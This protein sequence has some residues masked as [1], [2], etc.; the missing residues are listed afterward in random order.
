MSAEGE[1]K[2]PHTTQAAATAVDQLPLAMETPC[3][4]PAVDLMRTSVDA[5]HLED[6]AL[7]A[8]LDF[9]QNRPLVPATPRI[10]K[11]LALTLQAAQ[12]GFSVLLIPLLVLLDLWDPVAHLDKSAIN[13]TD[14][15]N[16]HLPMPHLLHQPHRLLNPL[17]LCAMDK[18]MTQRHTHVPPMSKESKS[19]ARLDPN[20]VEM[21][22]THHRVTVVRM[23]N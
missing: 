22:A 15:A 16:L 9:R 7:E 21:R 11:E 5:S 13:S 6:F 12:S 2:E 20:L 1:Y 14:T 17:E 8:L 10:L 3:S 23:V 4:Q 18:H 19:C